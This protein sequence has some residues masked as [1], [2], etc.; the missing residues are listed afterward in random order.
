M[1]LNFNAQLCLAFA[2]TIHGQCYVDSHNSGEP[3]RFV[4]AEACAH[5]MDASAYVVYD[6]LRI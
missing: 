2:M 6:I 5:K 4:L 1:I 3:P